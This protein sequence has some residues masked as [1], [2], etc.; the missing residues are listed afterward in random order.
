MV[1][2]CDSTLSAVEGIQELGRDHQHEI[3]R[4]TDAAMEGIIPL[5]D[6][7]G[8]RLELAHPNRARVESLTR[9][10]IE[11]L[12]PDARETVAALRA[13]GIAVRVLSGGLLPAVRGL[14]AELGIGADAVA[15]VDVY[16]DA[17]GDYGGFDTTSPLG[18]SGGKAVVLEQW[19]AAVAAPILLVGDGA[20]DLEAR[21]AAD[22]F[23][24]FAGVIERPAVTSA[25][26]VTVRAN[27][28]A[29]ILPLALGGRP[30]RD[31][32]LRA[33]FERGLSL[34]DDAARA[35]IGSNAND[36]ER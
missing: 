22:V 9:R 26:D 34:L 29:P 20:T 21:A 8:R 27:S 19:R 33:L 16:F 14:A 31:A 24:A 2:D 10:Y 30:P 6:V 3:E 18:R 32:A 7:Y 36:L 4:L 1:F 11:A 5:E 28:L 13:E 23:V 15:A 25:A 12:V 35:A 17:A